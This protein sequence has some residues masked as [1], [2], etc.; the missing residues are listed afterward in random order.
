MR[1]LEV[2]FTFIIGIA[3]LG[4]VPSWNSIIG[5]IIIVGCRVGMGIKKLKPKEREPTEVA[6]AISIEEALNDDLDDTDL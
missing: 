1:N 4:E 2:V 5:A 3:I 6:V